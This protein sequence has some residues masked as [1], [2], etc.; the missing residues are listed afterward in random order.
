MSLSDPRSLFGIHSIAPYDRSTGAFFGILKVLGDSELNFGATSV[1]L[2]GGSNKFPWANETVSLESSFTAA[3]KSYPDFY[4]EKFAGASLA[5]V[6]ASATGTVEAIVNKKGTS[7]VSATT[8]IASV[9]AK[10]T[11]EADLKFGTVVV[12]AISTTTVDLF[13]STDINFKLRGTATSYENDLLKITASP[14]TIPDSGGTVDVAD[15]GLE[16]TGGSGTVAM[17]IG[18]TAIFKVFP[19]HGGI[20]K[21]TLGQSTI[22]FPEVGMIIMAQE[23]ATTELFEIV[24]YKAKSEAGIVLPLAEGGFS[25][26]SLGV[27]LLYDSVKDA[28]ALVTAVAA[29]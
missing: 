16:F 7:V 6:A 19:I 28:V 24:A 21:L 17:T 18:D 5:T 13:Y 11:D 26:S 22:T 2:R 12:E 25:T 27:K 20:S 8:G 23:R 10:A 14:I 9:A 29:A 1:D 3:V 15:Y 4:F